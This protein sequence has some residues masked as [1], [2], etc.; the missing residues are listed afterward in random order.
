MRWVGGW[1]RAQRER[2]W[3]WAHLGKRVTGQV[4]AGSLIGHPGSTGSM[5]WV[6]YPGSLS[7]GPAL[8]QSTACP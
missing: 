3:Y 4:G 1:S 6:G 5:A 7:T 2:R 8:R